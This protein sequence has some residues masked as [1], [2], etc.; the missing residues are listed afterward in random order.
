MSST[1][2]TMKG[3]VKFEYGPGNA[4]LRTL[5][6]PEPGV[7]EVRLK[8][9]KA[10]ICG[11]DMHVYHA[12]SALSLDPPVVMGH[13]FVGRI[14]KLGQGVEGYEPGQK[15]TSEI[16][17]GVDQSCEYCQDG[18][19][20]MCIHRR[21]I[22]Y[23]IDGCFAE[24]IVVPA[25][26]LVP[27]PEEVNNTT[28]AMIEPLAC[29]CRCCFDVTPIHAGDVVL[30]MGAGP[31]GQ[32]NAQ[33][34]K[35]CGATVIVADI[36]SGS[37][38]LQMAKEL[39]ADYV[40]NVETDDLHALVQSLTHGYGADA[41]IDCSGSDVGINSCCDELRK[42]GI[43]TN[44]AI[45]KPKI[46]FNMSN[47]IYREIQVRGSM[48]TIPHNWK[49]AVRLLDRGLVNLEPLATEFK[50]DDWQD[51]FDY[52]DT[53]EGYKIIFNIGEDE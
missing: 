7:G 16:G 3:L 53:R 49:Q 41:A 48:S 25:R 22:G 19:T 44:F 39:G 5:P 50:L 31:M 34:A 27:V 11:S 36:T 43:F 6:V 47:V 26:Y 23:V 8:V 32:M 21:S 52:Y 15:V 10:G 38:R 14:D 40:V 42:E 17:V 51:A 29:C 33:V 18:F 24:Y 9:L 46:E 35:A 1:N 30:V 45:G 13:E 20:N 28:A 37:A 12:D 2:A 4:E